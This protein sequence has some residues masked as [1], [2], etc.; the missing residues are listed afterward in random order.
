MQITN[1]MPLYTRRLDKQ[2]LN[3]LNRMITQA[4]TMNLNLKQKEK[5]R[6]KLRIKS[7]MMA[8]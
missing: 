4:T 3:Q 5:N 7:E 8:K 6:E 1:A 2:R